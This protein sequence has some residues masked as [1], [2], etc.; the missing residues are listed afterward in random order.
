MELHVQKLLQ[1]AKLPSFAHDA[2]AGMDLY[3]AEAITIEPNQRA[4]VR[5]GLAIAIPE[6]YVGLV[7]DKGGI[8]HKL[9]MKTLGGVVD[10]GYTGEWLIGLYNLSDK[11]HTFAVGD[12]ITQF[13]VQKVEHP[14]VV[15]VDSLAESA[16]GA[17]GFGSTGT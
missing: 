15:E 17:N 13:L 10:A 2:D 9:G 12:K 14:T 7:W 16:R 1:D 3:C 5:T 11:S 6:G 4:Q 8:S